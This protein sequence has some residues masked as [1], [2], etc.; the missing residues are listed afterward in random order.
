MTGQH[1]GRLRACRLTTVRLATLI[2]IN[3]P[4]TLPALNRAAGKGMVS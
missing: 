3:W 1:P 2:D 4:G